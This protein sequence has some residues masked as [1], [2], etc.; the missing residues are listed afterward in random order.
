MVIDGK[1]ENLVREIIKLRVG[2]LHLLCLENL[3]K[4]E[5]VKVN[6]PVDT[7]ND[8]EIISY[9]RKKFS[10]VE[11]FFYFKWNIAVFSN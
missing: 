8:H 3:Y 7:S 11:T 4:E 1:I 10:Q 2:F 5:A 9:D 6:K